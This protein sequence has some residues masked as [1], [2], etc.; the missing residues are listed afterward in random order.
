MLKI[1]RT[2]TRPSTDIPFYEA[3]ES[4]KE[5]MRQTYEETGLT[6]LLEVTLSED[7]LSKTYV[8]IYPSQENHLTV[9]CDVNVNDYIDK[10][11]EYNLSNGITVRRIEEIL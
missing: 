8:S 2:L 10:A 9:I 5:Y 11:R 6:T 4:F 1:T 3:E 7:G